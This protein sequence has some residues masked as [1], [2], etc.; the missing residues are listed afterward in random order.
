V[1]KTRRDQA[2][3]GLG[4]CGALAQGS[5][6]DISASPKGG[7]GAR[8]NH[9]PLR[10]RSARGKK[11]SDVAR[12]LPEAPNRP[13]TQNGDPQGGRVEA[14]R[15]KKT[16][17]KTRRVKSK[18]VPWLA[19]SRHRFFVPFCAARQ[20][21]REQPPRAYKNGRRE[22]RDVKSAAGRNHRGKATTK[23]SEPRRDRPAALRD[24]KPKS[25]RGG[26]GRGWRALK[27]CK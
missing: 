2:P 25:S 21:K 5:E 18:R 20:R 15:A 17:A 22:E 14:R 7:V 6:G 19:G 1:P 23:P 4:P 26:D 16:G 12:G 13:P 24:E 9:A 3:Q 11:R 27:C 10:G 8:G